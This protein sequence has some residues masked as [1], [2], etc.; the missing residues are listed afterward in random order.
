LNIFPEGCTTNGT[1]LAKFKKGAF[2]SL[3]PVRLA[4]ITYKTPSWGFSPTT[5]CLGFINSQILIQM[6]GFIIVNVDI[7][8]VFEPNDYFWKNHWQEGKEEK[9]EAFARVTRDI[10]AKHG[11]YGLSE[12]T[13]ED[14][15]DFVK[16]LK[17][18]RKHKVEQTKQN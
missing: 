7:L 10:I 16:L 4:V 14:K 18:K 8:P 6:C 11:G 12:C 5:D 17:E 3:R 15:F 2:N 9:W 13:M 1:K